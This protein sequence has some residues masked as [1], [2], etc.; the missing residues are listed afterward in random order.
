MIRRLVF[1]ALA[2]LLALSLAGCPPDDW[3]VDSGT[4]A[5]EPGTDAVTWP[6]PPVCPGPDASP[7][8]P[9]CDAGTDAGEDAG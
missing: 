4:D 7:L 2:A 1:T 6:I 8:W 5:T 9:P 3:D